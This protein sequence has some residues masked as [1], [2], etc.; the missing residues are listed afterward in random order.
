M[1]YVKCF[2]FEPIAL[3]F[4]F[5]FQTYPPCS[6]CCPSWHSSGILHDLWWMC[7]MTSKRH[8]PPIRA[9]AKCDIY[10]ALT[11]YEKV[12]R[13]LKKP[14]DVEAS[15]VGEH[16][17]STE[18]TALTPAYEGEKLRKKDFFLSINIF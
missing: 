10:I 11:L 5:F 8:G 14:R 12:H 16:W 1:N 7:L 3:C 6:A 15:Q 9:T 18:R 4:F 17:G 2:P 13:P